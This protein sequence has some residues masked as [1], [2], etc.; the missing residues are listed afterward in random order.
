MKSSTNS[1][2]Q[3]LINWREGDETALDKLMPVVYKEL[4]RLAHFYMKGERPGHLLQTTA[5]INEAYLKLVDH[6]GIR[7]QNRAHFF[8]V[9]AQAMRRILVDNARARKYVKRG[10]GA[11]HIPLDAAHEIARMRAS[12]LIALDDALIDLA[13]FD[14]RKSRVVELRYFGGLSIVETA[15][16]LGISTATVTRDWETA[17]L[18][19]LRAMSPRHPKQPRATRASKKRV[20]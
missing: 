11:I 15:E 5:L 4:R 18:L 8:G 16:V 19:L 12:E 20:Q 13:A 7:W 3:L 1:V 9:A 2:S 10:G 14:P 17:K 6:K